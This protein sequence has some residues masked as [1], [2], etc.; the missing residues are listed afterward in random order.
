MDCSGLL[1]RAP[2]VCAH[3]R[4]MR[5]MLRLGADGPLVLASAA[6][7]FLVVVP[8][9]PAVGQVLVVFGAPVAAVVVAATNGYEAAV[10]FS[11]TPWRVASRIADPLRRVLPR[12]VWDLRPI[13]IALGVWRSLTEGPALIGAIG[14]LALLGFGVLTYVSPWCRK[15]L[16]KHAVTSPSTG[17]RQGESSV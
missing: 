9:L 17:R 6:F 1:S 12:I 10:A 14:A 11:T 8:L 13:P 16:G 5:T 15:Q 4:D 3:T 7:A 2:K